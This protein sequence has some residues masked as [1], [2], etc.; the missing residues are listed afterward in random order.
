MPSI[1]T[2]VEKE[3]R[4]R[5]EDH[6]KMK[7]EIGVIQAKK[8][9]EPPEAERSKEEFSPKSSEGLCPGWHLDFRFMASRAERE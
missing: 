3:R 6:V 8:H 1:L 4:Y 2:R 7:A 5:R 9:Q